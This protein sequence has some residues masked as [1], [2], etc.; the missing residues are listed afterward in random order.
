MYAWIGCDV[1]FMI[2]LSRW[3]KSLASPTQIKEEKQKEAEFAK[4]VMFGA[5]AM[6][7]AMAKESMKAGAAVH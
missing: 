6:G 5:A 4:N 1:I 3:E 7:T 2:A